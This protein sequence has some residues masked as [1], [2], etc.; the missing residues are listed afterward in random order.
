MLPIGSTTIAPFGAVSAATDS[1]VLHASRDLPLMRTPH[2]PQIAAWHEHRIE[3]DPSCW[4]RAWRI[5]SR[6]ERSAGRSTP[7]SSQYAGLPDS[8]SKRRIFSV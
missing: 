7:N 3:S 4:S 1:L 5:A 8:G 6:T 2:D